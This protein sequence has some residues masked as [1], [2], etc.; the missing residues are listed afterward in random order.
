MRK[1]IAAIVLALGLFAVSGAFAAGPAGLSALGI[2]GSVGSNAGALSGATGLSFKFGS[3]PVVGLTYNFTS[4]LFG[5][6]VDY[7]I[8]DA[9]GI[10][11]AL[12]Y[13]LGAGAYVGIG[14]GNFTAG[15]RVPVGLQFWP[16]KKLELFLSPVLSVPL[17]PAPSVDIGAEFGLRVHF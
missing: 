10:T 3:F 1:K 12:S 16:I 15:L 2:Y 14:S 4:S 5:A 7:Y 6:S 11:T 8:I 17:I 13:F 9:Q